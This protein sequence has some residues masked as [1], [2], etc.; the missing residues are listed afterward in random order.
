MQE[1]R[2]G[3]GKVCVVVQVRGIGGID[4]LVN[5]GKRW[6]QV[7]FWKQHRYDFLMGWMSR[8]RKAGGREGVKGKS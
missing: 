5:I 3:T 6:R 2:V 8:V 7:V 1:M 4:K